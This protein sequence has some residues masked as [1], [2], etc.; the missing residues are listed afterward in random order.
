VNSKDLIKYGLL[1]LGAYLIWKYVQDHGGISGLFG[2][3]AAAGTTGLNA[4]GT[5]VLNQVLG[6]LHISPSVAASLNLTS[7]QIA[8]LNSTT[9]PTGQVPGPGFL[10]ELAFTPAQMS[11]LS[12]APYIGPVGGTLPVGSTIPSTPVSTPPP[13]TTP[14]PAPIVQPVTLAPTVSQKMLAAAGTNSLNMDQWC[15]YY[16]AATGNGCPVDPGS[17]DP[18]VYAGAGI[19][20]RTTPTDVGTWIAIMQNQA[21]QLGL[22]GLGARFTPAWLM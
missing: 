17:I 16:S 12:G 20:D 7:S 22:M 5:A 15:F 21:P 18:S 19:V 4:N 10:S 9:I 14:T 6:Q 2:T 13:F 3:T 8:L 11:I 1:A